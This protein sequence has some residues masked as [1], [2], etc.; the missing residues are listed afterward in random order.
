MRG[1]KEERKRK[2]EGGREEL[3]AKA[4]EYSHRPPNQ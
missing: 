3:Q 1:K 4:K 2:R